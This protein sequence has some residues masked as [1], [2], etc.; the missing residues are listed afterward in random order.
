MSLHQPGKTAVMGAAIA[1]LVLWGLSW[2][3]SYVKLGDWSLV[4]A[5]TIA[6]IKAGFVVLVFMELMHLRASVRIAATAAIVMFSVMFGL[7][8]IDVVARGMASQ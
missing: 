3:L 1:L 6:V 5:L 8:V 4:I 2:A 7:V